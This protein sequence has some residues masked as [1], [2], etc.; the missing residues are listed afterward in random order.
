MYAATILAVVGGCAGA[1]QW[2]QFR[3]RRHIDRA[4]K[5]TLNIHHRTQVHQWRSCSVTVANSF[6][7]ALRISEIG[8]SQS[9]GCRIA[10]AVP[11][12]DGW[13]LDDTR[14]GRTL[15]FNKTIP[16]RDHREVQF[17]LRHPED[18]AGQRGR[19]AIRV[20][21]DDL[22]GKKWNIVIPSV[23]PQKPGDPVR[24]TRRGPRQPHAE[25][26]GS[27]PLVPT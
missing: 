17:F 23:L 24:W 2:M 27:P 18:D 3:A 20:L 6:D 26:D 22:R 16:L 10:T 13:E 14:I 1:V 9:L 21:L 25:G 12:E 8:L 11:T 15:V 19:L 4:P 5:V 7:Y